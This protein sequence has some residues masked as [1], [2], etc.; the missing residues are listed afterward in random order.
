MIVLVDGGLDPSTGLVNLK[1][2]H[3]V[4]NPAVKRKLE[5][6]VFRSLTRCLFCQMKP[7]RKT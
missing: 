7:L 4:G 6:A 3:H 1:L 2:V 5:E